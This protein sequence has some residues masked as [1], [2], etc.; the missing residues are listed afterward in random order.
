MTVTECF[1]P[2][3]GGG[4]GKRCITGEVHAAR[5]PAQ[6]KVK[7]NPAESWSAAEAQVRAAFQEHAGADKL[8]S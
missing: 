7:L 5:T 4:G 2:K 8:C 1:C 3:C 6:Q